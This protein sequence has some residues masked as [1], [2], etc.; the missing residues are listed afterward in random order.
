MTKNINI[1]KPQNFVCSANPDQGRFLN[2]IS[3]ILVPTDLTEASRR[4]INCA[5]TFAR[6]SNAHLTLL[7]VYEQSYNLC[8]LR[9]SH[10]YG[11]I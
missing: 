1:G 5:V 2:G 9:G 6:S 10:V 7:H 4:T 11:A 8:Y 3:E